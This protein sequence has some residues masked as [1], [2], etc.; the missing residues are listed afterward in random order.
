LISRVLIPIADLTPAG[1]RFT[2]GAFTF[3]AFSSIV[4]NS[5]ILLVPYNPTA[6]CCPGIAFFF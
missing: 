4:S 2:F 3:S 1:F 6:S 5:S